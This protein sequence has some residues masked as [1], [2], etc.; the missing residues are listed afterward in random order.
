MTNR[1]KSIGLA[2]M[3]AA[4]MLSASYAEAAGVLTIGRREDSTTFDPIKT[5]QNID[6]WVFSNVYDVLIRVDKTGT[7]LEPGLAESWTVSDDG[8]TYTLKIRD[9]KFSDGSPL[10]AEDAAFSLLRIRDDPASLWSDSYKVIDT[11]VATDAHTLTIKLKNPSAPFLS[12]LAL[13]NASVISKKGME[14]LGAEAYGEKPI[15]SGAFVVDEWR[16]GDRVILKKNPNFWEADRVKLDGVE[17]ISVPDD[18]TR[19]LNVQA[20]ELD[21][22]IFVPFSRVEELKKDPNLN[23][24]I[25]ASTREDHLLINHAHGAL[26]K[27]EVR[28][29]LDLAIDKKAIVDTVTFGQGTVANSYIPKGALYYYA[30]NLQRPYDPAKAKEML[31]AAGASDLTLN[32]VVRAGDEVDEQTAVLVQQQLQKAGITANLQKVDPSQE[33]D[34]L[35]AGDYDI[36]VN[37]WTNDILDPDQKTTFVLGHDSNN[38]Y[39]TNYKNEAVKEL[40]AKARLE[41]DPKKREEMYVNLQRMA[42]DDVNWIDLYYSP[43]INVSRKSIENFHQNPLGRFFLEDTVK[44]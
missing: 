13:P 26:G 31:A 18:N 40:V 43:Y 7:K 3:L 10:T 2:A 27:K 23:V 29:A 15:A 1:W 38:N 44:N 34:M 39:L 41:L 25:N 21:A 19:M 30:D 35:V 9:T 8:L 4:L 5:A 12:T 22:A 14:S 33:W 32:Y 36:S 42:K 20:G 11:A 6:N 24:D 28:Q 17:W 37:Y 16:R